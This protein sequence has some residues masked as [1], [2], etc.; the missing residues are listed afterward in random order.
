MDTSITIYNPDTRL[1]QVPIDQKKIWATAMLTRMYDM[2]G[3]TVDR[4]NLLLL[5]RELIRDLESR[6]KLL[7]MEEVETIIGNGV[8]GDYGEYYGLSVASIS[9]WF[10]AYMDS[11]AHNEYLASKVTE[12][13]LM[14]P[15]KTALTDGEVEKI[16]ISGCIRCFNEF[17]TSGKFND[18]GRENYYFLKKKGLIKLSE[19]QIRAYLDYAKDEYNDQLK[20]TAVSTNR[21]DAKTA[22]KIL[23][24]FSEVT[25]KNASVQSIAQ[26]NAMADF[27]KSLV[28]KKVKIEDILK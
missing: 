6:Y 23:N 18:Y 5:V 15:E 10:K 24:N 9:K 11:G 7:A 26:Y 14:L 28:K 20:A 4:E 13:K 22:L 8:R 19:K 27:F 3:Q 1:K 12:L 2:A 21:D 25:D 16:M 17:I